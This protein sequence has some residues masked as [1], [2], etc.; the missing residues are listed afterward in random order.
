[1][2][3]REEEEKE[4]EEKKKPIESLE[5]DITKIGRERR[6]RFKAARMV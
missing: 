3:K 4:E 1:M 2:K 6:R 5:C